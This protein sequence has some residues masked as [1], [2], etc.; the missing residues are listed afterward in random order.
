MCIISYGLAYNHG[1]VSFVRH[2]VK[3]FTKVKY[4]DIDWQLQIT[5]TM[6]QAG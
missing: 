6:A 5:V 1:R 2:N 4:S 3:C